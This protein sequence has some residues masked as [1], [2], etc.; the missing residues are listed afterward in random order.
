MKV[1]IIVAISKNHVIGTKAGDLPWVL[2]RD[3]KHFRDTTHGFPCIIG[4]VSLEGFGDLLPN[5][6]NI[7][8]SSRKEFFNAKDKTPINLPEYE[9][10][11]TEKGAQYVIVKSVKEAVD[12]AKDVLKTDLVYICGGKGI[13]EDSQQYSHELIITDIDVHIEEND[14]VIYNP[15]PS[16]DE[17]N[18]WKV[19]NQIHHPKDHQ[20]NL[21][22]SITYY[23]KNEEILIDY[24]VENQKN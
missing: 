14:V 8:V 10:G 19:V 9:T 6:F 24:K 18:K 5:R 4:R 2:P 13:Y 21:D 3:L 12:Y 16:E 20:N 11:I 22:F 17:R 1:S 15:F 23:V 7:I